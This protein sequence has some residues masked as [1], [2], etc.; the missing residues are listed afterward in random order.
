MQVNLKKQISALNAEKQAMTK[1]LEIVVRQS[2]K[3]C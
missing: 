3:N 2:Q 1:Q